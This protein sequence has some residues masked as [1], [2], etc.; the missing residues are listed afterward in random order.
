MTRRINSFSNKKIF[1]FGG[2]SGIGLAAAKQLVQLGGHVAIFARGAQRLNEAVRAIQPFRITS[3]QQIAS[4]AVDVSDPELVT[5]VVRETLES[6]GVPDILI[7]CAGR[8]YPRRFE[9]VS[10]DQLHETMAIN[11]YGIWHVIQ[12]ALPYMKEKGGLIVNTSSVSGFIGVYGYTDYAASKY[13]IMGLTEALR[14]ELKPFNIH[15]SVLCPPD[16]D[17]PGLTTE[18]LT[19]PEETKA[20]SA[21]A[22]VMSPD[23]VANALIAGMRKGRSVILP[24]MDGKLLYIAKRLFPGVVEFV[25]DR[26]IEKVQKR[27]ECVR[28]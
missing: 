17:T 14:S 19:K 9:E 5:R 24:G 4:F 21:N 25:M 10:L 23:A 16:T 8:A 3:T 18:N 6:F 28:R 1:I 15:V 22:K 13:A 27:P 20:I 7:N 12:A 11:L 26:T 2:S